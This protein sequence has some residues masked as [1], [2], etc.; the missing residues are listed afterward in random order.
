MVH[1]V[2]DLLTSNVAAVSHEAQ[3]GGGVGHRV[4]TK[5]WSLFFVHFQ[6]ISNLTTG[7]SV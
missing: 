4:F 6:R 1:K 7:F 5:I 3:L 2:K